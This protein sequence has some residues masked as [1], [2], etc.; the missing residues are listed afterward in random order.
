VLDAMAEV[1]AAH[2]YAGT[3]VALVVARA[4]VSRQ[5]FYE[6]FTD[7]EACFLAAYDAILDSFLGE[8]SAA[9]E[10]SAGPWPERIRATIEALLALL[11]AKPAF[12]RMCIIEV[13]AAGPSALMRY[14][15]AAGALAGLFEQ[16][17]GERPG[18]EHLPTST[19]LAV[20]HGGALAIRD[21][22]LDGADEQLTELLPGLTYGM[23]VPY[24]GQ[25]EALRVAWGEPEAA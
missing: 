13:L 1:C 12:T 4:G 17:R 9:Y 14:M 11:A 22:I 10:Q 19:A 3:S 15:S 5:T 20:I 6:H 18:H 23:L 16:G 25:E 2:G 24:I 8:V 7:K 21:Q